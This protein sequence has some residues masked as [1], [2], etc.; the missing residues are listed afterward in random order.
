MQK[1]STF[2]LTTCLVPVKSKLPLAGEVVLQCGVTLKESTIDDVAACC[3][4]HERSAKPFSSRANIKAIAD[5]LAVTCS[6]GQGMEFYMQNLPGKSCSFP[7]TPYTRPLQ[8]GFQ[9]SQRS[10]PEETQNIADR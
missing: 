10:T 7:T 5:T 3:H 2:K 4:F 9:A 6:D 8:T 1:A